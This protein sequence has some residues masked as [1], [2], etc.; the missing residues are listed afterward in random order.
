MEKSKPKIFISYA[1]EDVGIASRLCKDLKKHGID[2]W[3]D[4]ESLLGGQ[5]WKFEINKAIKESTYFLAVLSKVSVDSIGYVQ[6]E[7]KTALEILDLHPKNKIY[8]LPVRIEDCFPIEERLSDL[9]WINIFP[10]SEYQNGLRKI[11]KVISPDSLILRSDLTILSTGSA[12]EMI[13]KFDFYDFKLNP[14]GEGFDH[15]YNAQIVDADKIVIDE[16]TGLMWQQDGSPNSMTFGEAIDWIKGLNHK[17]FA[18]FI[19]WW[20]P[21]LEEAMSLMEPEQKNGDL[22]IDILFDHQQR[23]IW[24]SDLEQDG[25]EAW[26]VSFCRGGCSVHDFSNEDYYVR[27]VRSG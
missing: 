11:L 18:G 12:A 9:H 10:E 22:H 21:T 26:V 24:T 8:I 5:N 1:H 17:K 14:E 15:K 23:D 2:I 6:K 20:L 27:A 25:L 13:R 7:L 4:N 3:F 19:D 16:V